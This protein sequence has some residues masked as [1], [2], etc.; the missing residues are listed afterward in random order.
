MSVEREV[1]PAMAE[2]GTLFGVRSRCRWLDAGTPATYL[3]AHR[4]LAFRTHGSAEYI[5]ARATV[6]TGALVRGS[7]VLPGAAVRRGGTVEN[8]VLLPGAEVGRGAVVSDSVVGSGAV[9]GESAVVS[10][11][12]IVGDGCIVSTGSVHRSAR[13]S[14]ES[15][16][17]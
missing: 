5:D 2:A 6:D 1:F 12:S 4:E 3:A 13:I 17:T 11:G 16:T 9:V 15:A 7:V 10:D 14:P 8:S